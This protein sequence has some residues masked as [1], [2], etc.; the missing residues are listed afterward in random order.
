MK[1]IS[2][3]DLKEILRKHTLA[4]V[5]RSLLC[6]RLLHRCHCLV[7]D[8]YR[9]SIR[10]TGSQTRSALPLAIWCDNQRGRLS[11][12]MYPHTHEPHLVHLRRLSMCFVSP[13]L[14]YSA[15]PDHHRNPIWETALQDGRTGI[16]SIWKRYPHKLLTP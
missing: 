8:Y 11:S 13:P 14:L 3:D 16:S 15:L 10:H 12:G 9:Y 6:G 4:R 7:S 5:W 1:T 2:N